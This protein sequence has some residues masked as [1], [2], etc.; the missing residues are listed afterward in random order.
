MRQHRLMVMEVLKPVR[1]N[2]PMVAQF[3]LIFYKDI[4]RLFLTPRLT[5]K[6]DDDVGL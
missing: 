2:W 4:A 6:T 5:K 3:P 1:A